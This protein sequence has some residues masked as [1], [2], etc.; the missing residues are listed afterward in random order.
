M[1]DEGAVAASNDAH[2][3]VRGDVEKAG[4]RRRV[5]RGSGGGARSKV[6]S[7]KKEKEARAFQ[8]SRFDNPGLVH[9][10]SGSVVLKNLSLSLLWTTLKANPLDRHRPP[11]HLL[12]K[13]NS[14]AITLLSAA[15][16]PPARLLLLLWLPEIFENEPE[17][18]TAFTLS[19]SLSLS[20][21]T[22]TSLLSHSQ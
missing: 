13:L 7:E 20:L 14:S 19:L 18:I 9:I 6:R 15:C 10:R 5:W 12:R 1:S 4:G 3:E 16:Q 8:L 21:Y 17:I 11:T 2:E 22:S